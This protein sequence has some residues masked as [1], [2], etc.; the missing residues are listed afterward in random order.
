[1]LN[2]NHK[3]MKIKHWICYCFL[4]LVILTLCWW[5]CGDK[6]Y[7]HGIQKKGREYIKLIELYL[8][9]TGETPYSLDDLHAFR[10]SISLPKRNIITYER[11]SD[12]T[13]ILIA[14]L[15]LD[16]SYIYYSDI[17]IWTNTFRLMGWKDYALVCD[18]THS[19]D[20]IVSGYRIQCS[21]IQENVFAI[22]TPF[23]DTI[24]SISS[25]KDVLSR[26]ELSQCQL[27][28]LTNCHAFDSII[29]F[30]AS[31]YNPDTE[32]YKIF[33]IDFHLDSLIIHRHPE[34]PSFIPETN[35]CG[36]IFL[37][38]NPKDN[39][40][41]FLLNRNGKEYVKIN[42]D[43]THLEVGMADDCPDTYSAE[44]SE[45]TSFWTPSGI[46]L[47]MHYKEILKIK[48]HYSEKQT[49]KDKTVLLYRQDPN[50]FERYVLQRG[51]L[52]SFSFGQQ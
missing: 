11:Q 21:P 27:E 32:T 44:K 51:K 4:V 7:R 17:K 1:M 49:H 5:T 22:K 20:H 8:E 30:Y 41:V 23:V 14:P 46:R 37:Y 43:C 52:V 26:D 42:P 45:F 33:L 18:S 12:S 16:D 28:E 31:I 6:W 38:N 40:Q 9:N 19:F 3:D 24:L 39:H 35:I 2:Q 50:F 29:G 15:S 10:D 34:E 36:E 48:G 25:F 13:Y 47:N